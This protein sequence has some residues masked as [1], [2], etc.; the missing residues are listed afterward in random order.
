MCL[1]EV[2]HEKT[3]LIILFLTII[4][5]T[6]SAI[7][8]VLILGDVNR[9]GSVTIVG[10]HFGSQNAAF[11]RYNS[12]FLYSRGIPVQTT[13]THDYPD[14]EHIP[15]EQN[16]LPVLFKTSKYNDYFKENFKSFD[17]LDFI[18]LITAHIPHTQAVY[19][20]IWSLFFTQ[21]R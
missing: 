16:V 3:I 13:K 8:P 4:V 17:V 2:N 11:F 18:A 10:A 9:D 21:S 14:K 1:K 6:A 12:D 15:R 20:T 19:S 7:L 5:V